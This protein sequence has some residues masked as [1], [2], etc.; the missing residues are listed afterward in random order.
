MTAR[1]EA[2]ANEL[3][4]LLGDL[5][6]AEAEHVDAIAAVADVHRRGAVNLLHYAALRRRDRRDLQNDLLDLGVTSLATTEPNVR[7]KIQAARNLLRALT[8]AVGPWPVDEIGDVLDEGDRLLAVNSDA[9]FGTPHP[10][11]RTRIMVTLPT[12]AADGPALVHA[13]VAAGMDVARI[14]CAHDDPATWARM[15]A[16]V[17]AAAMANGR[18]VL[19]SM[20]LPGPKL[21]TGPI[22]AGPAVGRARVTHLESGA[23]LAPA[24]IWF[25]D[26]L[27]PVPSPPLVP[28][29]RRPALTVHVELA[30]LAALVVGDVVT[31]RDARGRHR[32]FRVTDT[33]TEG[34]RAECPRNTYLEE[35]TDLWSGA[36][37]T[38]ARGIAPIDRK[39][40]VQ[41]DDELVLTSDLTPVDLPAPGEVA[42]IGCT[43]P[44]AVQALRPGDRVLFDDGVIAAVVVSTR[45]GE[46][47]VRIS[48][49]KP[50]GQHLGAEKGI[51]LPD[52]LLPVPALTDDDLGHLPFIAEHADMV[53]M[54]FVRTPADVRRLLASLG[55]T[56]GEDLS[57]ILKI[58]T[59]E[60]FENLPAILLAAMRHRQ[61]AVMVARG[62]LA[63]EIGFERLAEVPRQILALCE[64]AH[65][66]TIWATQVLDG[67][68]KT[69]QASRAEITDAA[70][71]QRAECVMLNKGPHIVDAI[72]G[73]DDILTRMGQVQTKSRTLMRHIH[74]WDELPP[75]AP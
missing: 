26:I 59:R 9:V 32:A 34:A 66:P 64:A 4:S 12:E 60:G 31:M 38:P 21:R 55:P 51:N 65:V 2:L 70:S 46:A 30:W 52:T 75:G 3:D 48:H 18:G 53:A 43:L 5:E 28:P 1:L 61:I 14:N 35:G 44:D 69:G 25:T 56:G 15:A 73:L 68:A 22:V 74:S 58:E 41:V 13:L 33:G 6:V 54:S 27:D 39:L 63:V 62:D 37:S 45:P 7:A 11:R 49:T 23:M 10:G 40:S 16:Q 36:R 57:I 17:R 29:A 71:G 72:R 19:V 67:L 8:G 47:T 42:R 20:D 50:G 24:S